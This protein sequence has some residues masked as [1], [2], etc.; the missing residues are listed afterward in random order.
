MGVTGSRRGSHGVTVCFV[1]E[2]GWDLH[3]VQEA[4][5]LTTYQYSRAS[6]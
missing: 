5:A 4:L 3:N 6:L 2:E 1:S